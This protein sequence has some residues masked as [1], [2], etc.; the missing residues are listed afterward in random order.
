MKNILRTAALL[1]SISGM[2][3]SGQPLNLHNLLD[4]KKITVSNRGLTL[5]NE[6]GYKGFR[7]SEE[8]GEGVGWINGLEFSNG[9]IEFDVRGKNE[10]QHSFVGLAFHAKDDTTYDAIYLRPFQF[11]EQNQ[12][13]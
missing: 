3:Q 13:L 12:E 11:L 4:E 10:K 5:I 9:T 2:A 7:L 1:F 8:L 6:T